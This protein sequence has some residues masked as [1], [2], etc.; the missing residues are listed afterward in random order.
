[1]HLAFLHTR[2]QRR[3]QTG[4]AH[5]EPLARAIKQA[6][7]DLIEAI[8]LLMLFYLAISL[9]ISAIMNVYNNAVKLKER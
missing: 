5:I 4:A 9:A 2:G 3:T 1:M 8:F 6:R 7:G